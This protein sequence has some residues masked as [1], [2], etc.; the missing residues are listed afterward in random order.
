MTI[1]LLIS[2][3]SHIFMKKNFNRYLEDIIEG[4]KKSLIKDISNTYKNGQWDNKNIEDIGIEA[5]NNVFIISIKDISDN[6]I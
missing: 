1:I 4:R 3:S 5:I 2:F 6:V